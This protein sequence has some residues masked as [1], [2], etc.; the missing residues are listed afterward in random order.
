M[1]HF[2]R[3]L[4]ELILA[5]R[6]KSLHSDRL[7]KKHIITRF[8][9]RQQA[10]HRESSNYPLFLTGPLQEIL[11]FNR[12]N[13]LS[14]AG[15]QSLFEGNKQLVIWPFFK[16]KNITSKKL[17][18]LGGWKLFCIMVK[19]SKMLG[20]FHIRFHICLISGTN[21]PCIATSYWSKCQLSLFS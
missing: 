21:E 14:S 2:M 6:F 13:L 3:H 17:V 4:V 15:E 9:F 5:D 16:R 10:S 12:Q 11:N 7:A 18:S 8:C 20:I 1:R 19:M